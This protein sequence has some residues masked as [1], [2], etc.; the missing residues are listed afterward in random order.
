MYMPGDLEYVVMVMRGLLNS[1]ETITMSSLN[2]ALTHMYNCIFAHTEISFAYQFEF[3]DD[4]YDV[5]GRVLGKMHFDK[6]D[7]LEG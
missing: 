3:F 2:Q 6:I 1:Y 5:M 7:M 4:F